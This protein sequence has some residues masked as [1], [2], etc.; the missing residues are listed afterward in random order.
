MHSFIALT[1]FKAEQ[2]WVVVKAQ[3]LPI[4]IKNFQNKDNHD[5]VSN[6][7]WQFMHN[8]THFY[9][10]CIMHSIKYVFNTE[11]QPKYQMFKSCSYRPRNQVLCV[12]LLGAATSCHCETQVTDILQS[13][14]LVTATLQLWQRPPMIPIP[15]QKNVIIHNNCT[16]WKCVC[17]TQSPST[18]L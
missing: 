16:K 1:L 4:F 12:G 10:K 9:S 14:L 17:F 11:N 15:F 2:T 6:M 8:K 7:Y 13:K 3:T 18:T 5:S